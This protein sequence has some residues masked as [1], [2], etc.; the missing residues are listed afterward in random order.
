[1]ADDLEAFL[2]QAAQRRAARK[3]PSQPRPAQPAQEATPPQQQRRLQPQPEPQVV[4]A[5][6]IEDEPS[7]LETHVDTSK[8]DRRAGHLGEEVGQADE[9]LEARLHKKFDH[10]LG[11]L[12]DGPGM[13]RLPE[14][15]EEAPTVASEIAQLLSNPESVRHAIILSEVLTPP[16]HR[17]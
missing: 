8:F 12:D 5:L 7:R 16:H 9:Q 14:R 1:M 6:V 15:V 3:K 2:R 4:E 17:W 13:P 10:R 11:A